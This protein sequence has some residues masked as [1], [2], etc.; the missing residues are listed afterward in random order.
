MVIVIKRYID[1]G[2]NTHLTDIKSR[3]MKQQTVK[4]IEIIVANS[5][6]L[7]VSC[8]GDIN[9]VKKTDDYEYDVPVKH[10]LCVPE[11]TTYLLSVSQLIK[12]KSSFI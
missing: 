12:K 11:L 4:E 2:A 1:P 8:I 6:K 10:V 9:I 3:V 7:N 5:N